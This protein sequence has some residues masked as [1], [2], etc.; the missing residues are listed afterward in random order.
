M[1]LNAPDLPIVADFTRSI[2]PFPAMLPGKVSET[3][4]ALSRDECFAGALRNGVAG[5]SQR[6]R[7]AAAAWLT[8]RFGHPVAS[9]RVLVTNGTQGALLLLLAQF[10]GPGELLVTEQ[11][12]Y[13]PLD[14][15]AGRAH[16]RVQGLA[17]D[18]EGLVPDAFEKA[19]R[20][21]K[22]RALYCNPTLHNPTTAIMSEKRR[23]QIAAIARHHGVV[24]IED[25]P[26]GRLYLESPRP[27]AALA[28]DVCWY[29]MGATKCLA[30][31]LRIATLVG[32]SAQET[33]K[34]LEPIRSLSHWFPAPLSCAIVTEWIET[35][36]AE[37][38]CAAIYAEL[39]ARQQLA[40]SIL[41]G[42]DAACP[43]SAMQLWLT[44]PKTVHRSELVRALRQRGVLVRPSDLFAVDQQECP[45]AI[46]MS[47][48]SPLQRS[49]V[50]QGLRTVAGALGG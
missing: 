29:L 32:P 13:T 28:P 30:H 15:L 7:M 27:I 12:T 24:I 19:C 14:T 38:I 2:P 47:L 40:T 20:L 35:G 39:T 5:G 26:L 31:G 25:D 8:P 9:D 45:N 41:A 49:D 4:A 37:E 34:F 6:D 21:D 17:I 16:V 10:V 36:V 1:N 44:L 46:R 50:E 11:L 22:P 33:Q 3:F 48:S 23:L 18:A 42:F 43:P